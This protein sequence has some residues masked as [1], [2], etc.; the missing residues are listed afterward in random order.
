MI[1]FSG[2]RQP[3]DTAPDEVP[4]LPPADRPKVALTALP[5]VCAGA[6]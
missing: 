6:A 1:F 2:P 3:P 4:G 5:T